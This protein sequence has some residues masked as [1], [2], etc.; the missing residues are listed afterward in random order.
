MTINNFHPKI[1][2]ILFSLLLLFN[3]S[4]HSITVQLGETAPDFTLNSLDGKAVSLNAY[5]GSIVILIYWRTEQERSLMALADGQDIFKRYIDKGMQV[6]GLTTEIDK[7]EE[8]RNIVKERGID[9]PVLLDADRQ[10]FGD[11]EIR[12]YPSTVIIDRNSKLPYD[13]PGHSLTYKTILEAHLQYMLGEID[14]KKL[15]DIISFR[16]EI[17][18]ESAVMAERR[19][20]LALKFTEAQLYE[21]A[22][23]AAKKSIEVKSDV[24]KPR[25]LLGFLFL[26]TKE[27]D[28]A[29]QEFSKAVEIDPL[30]NDAKTGIGAALI[31]KGDIDRAI[32][33]LNAAVIANPCPER[34]YYELGRAYELKG[35]KDKSIE[36]YKKAVEKVIKR[37]VMPSSIK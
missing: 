35:E 11:Y 34:T 13:L 19:Y 37:Q 24:A 5:K 9:F 30:S 28:K 17:V 32:E 12:V 23:E 14:E 1:L 18:D 8:L 3:P 29:F 15:N 7:Q 2:I 31:L 27:G 16:R 36:M 20:N 10:V 22:I 4:A 21:Q 26:A 33:V 25:V 6:I